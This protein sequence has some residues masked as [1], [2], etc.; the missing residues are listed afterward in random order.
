MSVHLTLRA[1]PSVLLEAPSVRPDALAG[2]SEAEIAHLPVWYGREEARLGDFFQIRGARS[3]EV[4]VDTGDAHVHHLGAGM[5]RGRL[6]VAGPGGRHAGA[7]M[8]GGEIRI[9]GDADDWTGAEMQGGLIDV[10]GSAGDQLAGAYPG[11]SR[12]MAGGVVLVRGDVGSHAGERMRRGLVA[13]AG[14][15]GDYAAVRMIA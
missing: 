1:A 13:V 5:T 3:D 8:R 9:E 12:G 10:R 6:I 11:G 7:G 14:R 4:R 15:A 2:L